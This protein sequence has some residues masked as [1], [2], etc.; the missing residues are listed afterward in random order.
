MLQID[1]DYALTETSNA[2]MPERKLW[3]AVIEQAAKDLTSKLYSG[4]AD[5]WFKSSSKDTCSFQWICEQLNLDPD[6]MRAKVFQIL[7]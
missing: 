2:A 4:N 5:E 6:W 3:N 1:E 7:T